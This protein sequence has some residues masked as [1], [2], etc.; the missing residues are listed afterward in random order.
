MVS[1]TDGLLRVGDHLP[2]A[3]VEGDAE[4]QLV[5]RGTA[6]L[7]RP[8]DL[9][10]ESGS[11]EEVAHDR[12][13]DILGKSAQRERLAADP[14]REAAATGRAHVNEKLVELRLQIF[15]HVDVERLAD[16]PW[17][18]SI[19]VIQ[20]AFSGAQSLGFGGDDAV[21]ECR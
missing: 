9:D 7:Q 5:L 12:L 4:P 15:E 19:A 10:H 8:P 11:D 21:D 17:A 2:L 14:A 13:D 6:G 1:G 3:V 16:L 20:G 18:T